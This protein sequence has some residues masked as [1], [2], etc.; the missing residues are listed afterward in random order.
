MTTSSILPDPKELSHLACLAAE[1]GGQTALEWQHRAS[2]QDVREK[3]GPSDLVS[4][5]DLETEQAIR[6]VLQAHRPDDA[7]LG[8]EHGHHHGSSGVRWIVDP[9]DGTNSYLYGRSDWAVSVAAADENGNLLC[10]AVME[11]SHARLTH[12]AKGHGTWID[13]AKK[14]VTV[15]QRTELSEA[16]VEVNFGRPEQ[17]RRAGAMVNALVPSVRGLRRGGSAAVALANLAAGRNDGAWI[18]GLHLWDAA[19]GI[20]LV[21]EAGGVVGDLSGASDG[22]PESGNVLAASAELWGTLRM[23][24]APVYQP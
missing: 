22:F 18:P 16:L 8:E 21:L 24:L 20:V 4:R 10:G 19:A 15:T 14:Q 9:I 5:A 13:G 23:I 6:D 3:E 2:E 7:V 12:A 11:P 17:R 1:T